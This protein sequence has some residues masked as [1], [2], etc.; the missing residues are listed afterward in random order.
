MS[1]AFFVFIF[2]LMGSLA[3]RAQQQGLVYVYNAGEDSLHF[4]EL[5]TIGLFRVHNYLLVDSLDVNGDGHPEM[6]FHRY[7]SGSEEAHGGT[8][9]VSTKQEI[10]AF[11]IWD[12]QTKACLFSSIMSMVLSDN[13]FNIHSSYNGHFGE[14]HYSNKISILEDG[15][16]LVEALERNEF[17][18]GRSSGGPI[19]LPEC[20]CT[21][22]K[23]TYLWRDGAFVL[24]G[25]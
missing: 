21:L 20:Q 9:D 15:R 14:C 25:D 1:K 22:A 16:L 18:T 17:F 12:L 5:S 10:S 6:V 23:G 4:P 24:V 2:V 11:E 19:S 7:F 3:S 8:F 13:R